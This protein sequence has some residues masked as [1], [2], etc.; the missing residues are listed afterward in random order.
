MPPFEFEDYGETGPRGKE[1]QRDVKKLW[2][3]LPRGQAF[4][5]AH[6]SGCNMSLCWG[7]DSGEAAD[8]E[9]EPLVEIFQ[10]SRGSSE[11]LGAP[12]QCNHFYTSGQYERQFGVQEGMVDVALGQGLRLGFVASSDHMSTHGSY[13]CVYA[14]DCTREAL[15]E[16]LLARRCYAASDRILCE[17]RLS[18]GFMGEEIKAGTEPLT[19]HIR[20]AGT[21]PL[22]EVALMRDSQPYR[23][24]QPAGAEFEA[25]IDLPADECRGHYF[26]AR[27]Q[28]EDSNLA[29][30]SPIWVD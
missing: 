27:A 23:T 28:Q 29:W 25:A 30:A 8:P 19:A 22:R 9:L 16:A 4:T 20:F 15:M 14:S 5:L 10:S 2:A 1:L 12:T 7:L 3:T 6:H 21:G 17:F 13:A 26:Y 18:E 11:Y 24:W